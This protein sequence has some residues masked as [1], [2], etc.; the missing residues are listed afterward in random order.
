MP[1]LRSPGFLGREHAKKN[2]IKDRG[3]EK[4]DTMLW[5]Q[6]NLILDM[7]MSPLGARLTL[8]AIPDELENVGLPR[9]FVS[10]QINQFSSG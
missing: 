1:A 10:N 5:L 2:E 9:V 4:T 8:L 3:G 7:R 6:A